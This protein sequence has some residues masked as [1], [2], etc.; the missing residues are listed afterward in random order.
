MQDF[1]I[2]L[3]S[4]GEI[5]ASF[6][7]IAERL[8]KN[9]KLQVNESWYRLLDIEF[10]YYA[11]GLYEDVYAHKHEAQLEAGKWYFHGSGIDITFGDRRNYGGILIRA[12][13]KISADAGRSRHFIEKEIHGPINVKTEI[14]SNLAGAFEDRVNN[15]CFHP[16]DREPQGALMVDPGRVYKTKRIGLNM[17]KDPGGQ[18]HQARLRYLIFPELKFRDKTGIAKDIKTQFP[19]MSDE[20]INRLMGSKFL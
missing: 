20:E 17:A 5:P 12:I 3:N 10:Y 2:N 14:C 13:G 11:E 16:I 15:F 7:A 8:L 18:F 4:T 1:S 19:E 9:Y 6:S